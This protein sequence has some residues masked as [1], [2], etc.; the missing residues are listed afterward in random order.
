MPPLTAT[1]LEAL[2]RD[3]DEL[4][5]EAITGYLREQ[6]GERM[7]RYLAGAE[8]AVP[9]HPT[10]G[11]HPSVAYKERDWR[12]RGGYKI[13]RMVVEAYDAATARAWLFGTNSE[14]GDEAPIELLRE[15]RPTGRLDQILHAARTFATSPA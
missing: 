2:N 11:G 3:G 9:D 13:V 7:T 15:A 6:L 1:A 5:L 4:D 10:T 12:L 8:L 14:L